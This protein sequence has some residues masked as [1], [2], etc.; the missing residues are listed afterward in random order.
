MIK[1]LDQ[2]QCLCKAV[3]ETR[4]VW[5]MVLILSTIALMVSCFERGNWYECLHV[6]ELQMQNKYKIIREP[7]LRSVLWF[8]KKTF[9]GP[10]VS[11]HLQQCYFEF[12]PSLL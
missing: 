6:K 3:G 8:V 10:S 7:F 9:S 1:Y 4:G 11:L 12:H 5:S 2:K